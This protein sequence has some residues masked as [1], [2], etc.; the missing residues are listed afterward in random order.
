MKFP[1]RLSKWFSS[2]STLVL[3]VA[4]LVVISLVTGL[5]AGTLLNRIITVLFVN[6]IL[7]VGLQ[8]FMGNSGVLSFAHIGFMGIGAYASVLFSLTPQAK[9]ATLPDLYPFLAHVHLPFLVSLLIGGLIAA[10]VAAVFGYPLMRLS[11]AAG[12]ITMFAFLVI[13]HV[14]LVHWSTVTNGPRTLFGVDHFTF[15]WNSTV[16]GLLA[17]FIG[18]WFKESNL[19][20]MLRASRDDRHAAASVGVN[21]IVVRWIAFTI[22]AFLAGFAGGL[23]AHFITSFSPNSFYLTTTFTILTMLVVGGPGSI[24]GAVFGTV[25]VTLVYEGLRGIESYVNLSN[26]LPVALVGF[27]EVFMSAALIIILILRPSGIMGGKEITWSKKQDDK[28][29]EGA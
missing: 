13:I 11:E 20:L 5:F 22:S 16:F 7:V 27:T 19:G 3:L 14:V 12:A 6:L 26:L 28:L 21:M 4:T 17:V 9:A 29:N 23:W 15:L 2:N 8:I 18:Y 24:S 10:L 1:T 25:V